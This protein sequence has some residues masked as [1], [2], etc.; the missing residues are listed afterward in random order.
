[1]TAKFEIADLVLSFHIH[2]RAAQTNTVIVVVVEEEGGDDCC[3]D[4]PAATAAEI[5][6][7][8]AARNDS[9]AK[10]L[11]VAAVED[12]APKGGL[13]EERAVEVGEEQTKCQPT[14]AMMGMHQEQR[15]DR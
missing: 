1:M 4:V 5:L 10:N 9:I 6:R 15:I 3:I 14:H 12:F 7:K 13:A 8:K 2:R 11:V